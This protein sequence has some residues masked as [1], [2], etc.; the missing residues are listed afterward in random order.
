MRTVSRDIRLMFMLSH[1]PQ[2]CHNCDKDFLS[3]DSLQIRMA[4]VHDQCEKDAETEYDFN[5]EEEFY[6]DYAY[7][8]CLCQLKIKNQNNGKKKQCDAV[9][10]LTCDKCDEQFYNEDSLLSH[11]PRFAKNVTKNFSVRIVC[12]DM[13]PM[14]MKM[15]TPC[16]KIKPKLNIN[17]VIV[18]LEKQ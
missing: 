16:L 1:N 18:C 7:I 14:V 3:V 6:T 12:R 9:H 13:W 5:M 15:G 2:T 4:D 11:T 17:L 8:P 10:H